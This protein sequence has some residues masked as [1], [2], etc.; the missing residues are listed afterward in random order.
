MIQEYAAT[1]GE[2]SN[3]QPGPVTFSLPS[4]ETVTYA[5]SGL[6]FVNTY[7]STVTAAYHGAIIAAE[8]FFQSH[9]TNA[10]TIN[11]SF[12]VTTGNFVD[13]NSPWFL[14]NVTFTDLKNDLANHATTTD[15]QTAVNTLNNINADPTSGNGFSVTLAEA[16]VLG[17][18]TANNSHTDGTVYLSSGLSYFYN[19]SPVSGS[20]DAISAIEH[21]ISEEMGRIGGLGLETLSNGAPLWGAIDL[22]RYSAAGQRDYTGGGDGKPAYFSVD[23]TNLLTQFNNPRQVAGDDAD[24]NP[25]TQFQA[26]T[27]VPGGYDSFGASPSGSAGIVTQTDLRV[28]DIL[29]WTP[30]NPLPDLTGYLNM[31]NTTVMVGGKLKNNYYAIDFVPGPA[32]CST[33]V[34]YLS[35]DPTI[36]TADQ[37]LA[38]RTSGLLTA[39]PASGYNDHQNFSVTLP[40]GV[41]PGTY[42]LGA[43][44]DYNNQISET[45]ESNNVWNVAQVTVTAPPQPDLTGYLNMGNTM[46]M[47]SGNLTIDDYLVNFGP[48]MAPGSTTG[49][50]LSTDSTITTSDR[51]LT[52]RTSPSL[53][54]Y[55]AAGYNDHQNFSVTLPGD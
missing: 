26:A 30:V 50:Y 15:D 11:E 3:V 19:G 12:S 40:G 1:D 47:V 23:G 52:T 53:T 18:W 44:A 21:E 48:G 4:P 25:S 49:F 8:N 32:P 10:V 31:G 27:L 45:N 55:P 24:W 17:L 28:M 14:T 39:Y 43:M 6:V 5:G 9:F 37:L 29:G 36:T 34:F 20:Y 13:A 7:D 22:F 51:L 41:A 46:V 33:T 16:K 35:T 38:T 54:A 2:N 42:Y